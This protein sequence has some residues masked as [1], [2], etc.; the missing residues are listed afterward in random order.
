MVLSTGALADRGAGI[1]AVLLDAAGTLI[2]PSAPVGE[3]Y[4]AVA[5]RFGTALEPEKLT[6]A[7][8]EVFA[9]MPDLAFQWGT[10]EELRRL[11]RDWWH[12]LV[13]RVVE[14]T[15]CEVDGFDRFFGTLYDH[16]A[17]GSAWQCF[18]EVP[19]V[20]EGLRAGGC[21]LAVVSNF[22]SRLPGILQSLGIWGQVDAVV[23]SSEAGSAKPDAAIFRRA[24]RVLG[25]DPT[26]AV[27]VGDSAR[28]DVAG[29]R[30][31]G[32]TGVLIQR[33][34]PAG[35]VPGGAIQSLDELLRLCG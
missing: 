21:R 26:R 11:E 4:S 33:G 7:F 24:L 8:A 5:G 31:A 9:Q 10:R 18:P 13:Q 3:T 27:H 19:R 15:G 20:L 23:Y 16:Y 35:T 14:R 12:T 25:V 32:I 29:A 6:Q 34:P 2:R 30:A 28:A 22:D 17:A 1:D